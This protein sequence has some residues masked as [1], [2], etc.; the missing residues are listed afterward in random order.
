M[1]YQPF[2]H[3]GR[4][5]IIIDIWVLIFDDICYVCMA[6]ATEDSEIVLIQYTIYNIQ[7]PEAPHI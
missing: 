3:D 1:K 5:D 2:E 7:N 6:E 4:H